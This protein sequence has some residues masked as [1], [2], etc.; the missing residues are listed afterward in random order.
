MNIR[1][2]FAISAVI[3]FASSLFTYIKAESC[4]TFHVTSDNSSTILLDTELEKHI[5]SLDSSLDD[6]LEKQRN[7][8]SKILWDYIWK[9]YPNQDWHEDEYYNFILDPSKLPFNPDI[10]PGDEMIII[11][12]SGI[13]KDTVK[14]LYLEVPDYS[15]DIIRPIYIYYKLNKN[16][17]GICVKM[18][19]FPRIFG[20]ETPFVMKSQEFNNGKAIDKLIRC[21]ANYITS[22]EGKRKFRHDECQSRE[23]RDSSWWRKTLKKQ[24]SSCYT[25]VPKKGD[26]YFRIN[27]KAKES[28]CNFSI[29]IRESKIILFE[30]QDIIFLFSSK[31]K[32]YA[33]VG[34]GTPFSGSPYLL[35]I[36]KIYDNMK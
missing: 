25:F 7:Y 31:G 13:S 33:L 34:G 14:D 17:S 23:N 2:I 27:F 36:V 26:P 5:S 29:L 24:I 1:I 30:Y 32:D 20:G 3:I 11:D 16:S 6:D 10:M 12:G 28:F 8:C 35:S 9:E 19:D 18:H 15:K 21:I 4:K 22:E